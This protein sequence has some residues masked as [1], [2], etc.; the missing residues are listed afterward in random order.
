MQGRYIRIN[1]NDYPVIQILGRVC[2]QDWDKRESKTIETDMS[3]AEVSELFVDGCS[4]AIVDKYETQTAVLDESGMQKTTES[5]ELMFEVSHGETVYDNSEFNI[6]GDIVI[7]SD[8]TISVKM[9][10]LT[11]LEEAYE[12]LLGGEL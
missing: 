8:G 11:D 7:R 5:G 3:Y 2:D 1:G 12:M 9:G 10:K 4:W 6:L